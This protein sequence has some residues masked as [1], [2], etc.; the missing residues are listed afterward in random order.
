MFVEIKLINKFDYCF[1]FSKDYEI[2]LFSNSMEIEAF[3]MIASGNK[4]IKF[5]PNENRH[6]NSCELII[7]NEDLFRAAI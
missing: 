7:K 1:I 3:E 2:N 6:E 5:F 4:V